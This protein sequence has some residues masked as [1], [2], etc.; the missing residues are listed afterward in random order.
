MRHN[1]W[2][3]GFVILLSV[4]VFSACGGSGLSKEGTDL[5]GED[6]IIP[7][8]TYTNQ[9]GEPFGLSDL[10]GEIWLADFIFTNCTTVC[11]PMTA[12][13]TTVQK[14]LE[15]AGFKI[16]IVSFS[17]DPDRDTPDVLAEYADEYGAN[18]ETW[19]FLTG[20]SFEEIQHFSEDTFKAPLMEPPEG[21]DQI[22]HGISFYLIQSDKVIKSYNGAVDTP[23]EAIVEDA[24]QLHEENHQK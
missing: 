4:A 13:M 11:P 8:F 18:T 3:T 24:I 20:Y 2:V 16:P 6:W 22:G 17:V 12:N 5:S 21:S 19:Q 10:E 9:D 14:R 15:E 7:D 1:R 23:I